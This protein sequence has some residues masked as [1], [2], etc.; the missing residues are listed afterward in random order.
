MKT[1]LESALVLVDEF[2]SRVNDA[3]FDEGIT[4]EFKRLKIQHDKLQEDLRVKRQ[5][6]QQLEWQMFHDRQ[7]IDK[8]NEEIAKENWLLD[9][10]KYD[11]RMASK[12]RQ[13]RNFKVKIAAVKREA[14][15]ICQENESLAVGG[16]TERNNNNNNSCYFRKR[17]REVEF[18]RNGKK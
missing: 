2:K 9:D 11:E 7:Q 10:P 1:D 17:K 6:R 15:S 18:H 16:G 4:S 13:I 12:E 3:S 5:E 8:V 14:D